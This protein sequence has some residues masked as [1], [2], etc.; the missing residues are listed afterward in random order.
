MGE[1]N[2][3]SDQPRP[4]GRLESIDRPGPS[5]QPGTSA[6]G[7]GFTH[8]APPAGPTGAD[9]GNMMSELAENYK[10]GNKASREI[11]RLREQAS[12]LAAEK[13]SAEESHA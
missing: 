10:Y 7:S 12:I 11:K 1:S 9:E 13:L 2:V 3:S 4:S 5:K 6:S 8:E